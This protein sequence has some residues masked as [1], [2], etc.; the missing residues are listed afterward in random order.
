LTRVGFG[1]ALPDHLV[2]SRSKA[3]QLLLALDEAIEAAEVRSPE[4]ARLEAASV[5]VE[6][7]LPDLPEL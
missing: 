4:V 1:V 5:L 3:A 6:K 7:F 2:L